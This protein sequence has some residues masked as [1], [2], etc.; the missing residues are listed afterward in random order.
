MAGTKVAIL[1]NNKQSFAAE[2]A[3]YSYKKHGDSAYDSVNI[4]NIDNRGDL[5]RFDGQAYLRAGK[6]VKYSKTDLQSFTP[7]R[8]YI[9]D[10]YNFSDVVLVVDPDIFMVRPLSPAELD[11][12]Q[13]PL[14][15][16]SARSMGEQA[17]ASSVMLLRCSQLRHWN[18]E[19]TVE[20]LF[21]G[22]KDYD[23]LIHLRQE[24]QVGKLAA[25]W[26]DFDKLSSRT[27]LL[28]NTQR[29]T[30]PWRKG[31]RLDFKAH[32]NPLRFK[33]STYKHFA[34]ALTRLK[35]EPP[36]RYRSHPDPRQESLFFALAKEAL[37]HDASLMKKLESALAEQHVRR[38]LD[39][40]LQ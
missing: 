16:I 14:A 28:H 29:I 27:L 11:L 9:P 13:N 21:S 32:S 34:K 17:Y 36:H 26:N 5:D 24:A 23:N 39:V 33:Y 7:L 8:F 35:W 19:E 37:E 1:T 30:Q 22:E 18:F 10:I 40:L 15:A 4:I 2:V 3:A 38:D 31:L 6:W 25:E 12:M 20:A